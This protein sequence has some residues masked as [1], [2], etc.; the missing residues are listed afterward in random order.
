MQAFHNSQNQSAME[1][2]EASYSTACVCAEDAA[3]VSTI[4]QATANASQ[5]IHYE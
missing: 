3:I 4:K 1:A 2:V 5:V